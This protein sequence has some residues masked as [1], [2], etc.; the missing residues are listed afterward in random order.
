MYK[1]LVEMSRN[2]DHTTGNL[3]DYLHRQKYKIIGINLSRQTNTSVTQQFNFAGKLKE[4]NGAKM[5]FCC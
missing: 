5:F 4:H 3:L 2:N 1:K